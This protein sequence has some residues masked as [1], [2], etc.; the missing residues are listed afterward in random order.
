MTTYED[1]ATR[2]IATWNE[3]DPAARK[4]AVADLFTPD[5]RYV[6]PLADAGGHDALDATIAAVQ[7]RFPGFRFRLAGPVDGHH[8]QARFTWELG[9]EGAGAAPIAGFDVA[10]TDEEGRIR[11]VYGFLDR[12]PTS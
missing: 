6:D 8:D 12:V 7:D 9:P 3:T 5:A 1:L 11:S 10:V 4:A 2:Y